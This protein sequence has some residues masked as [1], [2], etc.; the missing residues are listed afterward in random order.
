MTLSKT[1]C[2]AVAAGFMFTA[3]PSFA[4]PSDTRA[5]A[6]ETVNVGQLLSK[7]GVKKDTKVAQSNPA[8]PENG[9][10]EAKP[11]D[12]LG[13]KYCNITPGEKCVRWV[14][15]ASCDTVAK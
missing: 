9:C 4:G 1:I 2:I 7:L 11:C 13:L 12:L 14:C 8:K 10:K 3:V 6:K 15:S 5:A